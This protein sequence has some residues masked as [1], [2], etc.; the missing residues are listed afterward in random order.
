MNI[1]DI[2]HFMQSLN[3]SEREFLSQVVVLV[4]LVLLVPATNAISERSFSALKRLKIYMRSTMA[5]ERLNNLMILH[6]HREKTDKLDLVD[7]ANR[8]VGKNDTRKRMFGRF[9]ECGRSRRE[10]RTV[11]TQVGG[12]S[13][14]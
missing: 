12:E 3:S 4:E 7:I 5:D 13:S 6:I 1:L 10:F 9:T 2:I 11:G 8:F 14:Q